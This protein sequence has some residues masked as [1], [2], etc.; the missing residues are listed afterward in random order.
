[1]AVKGVGT[2]GAT[3]V[4]ESTEAGEGS[5]IFPPPPPPS[6]PFSLLQARHQVTRRPIGEELGRRETKDKDVDSW[7]VSAFGIACRAVVISRAPMDRRM[8]M[9][10]LV[11]VFIR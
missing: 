11:C 3:E 2:A 6:P 9:A 1:M 8:D 7:C 5:K 10:A 4:V